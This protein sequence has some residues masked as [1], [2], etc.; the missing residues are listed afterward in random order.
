MIT[1]EPAQLLSGHFEMG[2]LIS[3]KS[4]TIKSA[5][6]STLASEAL[7]YLRGR[8]A[9]RMDPAHFRELHSGPS[10]SLRGV[11]ATACPRPVIVC[12]D[13]HNLADTV[14]SDAGTASDKRLRIVTAMLRQTFAPDTGMT[15]RWVNIHEMYADALTKV[16][17]AP[18]IIAIM[19]SRHYSPPAG[20]IGRVATLAQRASSGTARVLALVTLATAPTGAH[21]ARLQLDFGGRRVDNL[22]S[23]CVE[24]AWLDRRVLARD[25]CDP[26]LDSRDLAHLPAPL[27]VLYTVQS[28]S[29]DHWQ[30]LVSLYGQAAS[31]HRPYLESPP[32]D[33]ET[34]TDPEPCSASRHRH[35]RKLHPGRA[36][37]K[38]PKIQESGIQT[39]LHDFEYVP[40]Q[41]A[42]RQGPMIGMSGPPGCTSSD[43]SW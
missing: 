26:R 36:P 5:V 37:N 14:Q 43:A 12:T 24:M 21:A 29:R 23:T 4:G 31:Q 16:M 32:T 15:L 34:Q 30:S 13:S 33:D 38:M 17:V 18:A 22:R 10:V 35:P 41:D 6:R 39:R 2:H 3:Y 42:H 7:L 9:G 25:P 20:R 27:P 28:T 1:H 19:P 11:E 40:A 8:R